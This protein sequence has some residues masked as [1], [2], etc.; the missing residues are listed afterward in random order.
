LSVFH[1]LYIVQGAGQMS[2]LLFFMS[3]L[4]MPFTAVSGSGGT[5]AMHRIAFFCKG[6][7]EK[8]RPEP[9][10]SQKK[11]CLWKKPFTC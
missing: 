11:Q 9:D 8:A 3:F 4:V 1:G 7:K 5:A 2:R 6:K 10:P